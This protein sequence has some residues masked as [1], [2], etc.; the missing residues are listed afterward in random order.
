[1]S[2][3]SFSHPTQPRPQVFRV[4]Q[5]VHQVVAVTLQV[6]RICYGVRSGVSLPRR[7]AGRQPAADEDPVLSAI[8]DMC[9]DM[10]EEVGGCPQARPVPQEELSGPHSSWQLLPSLQQEQ[11]TRSAIPSSSTW[12][13]LQGPP[14]E[15]SLQQIPPPVLQKNYHGG[16]PVADEIARALPL[17]GPSIYWQH[18]SMLPTQ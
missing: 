8:L 9:L 5:P 18:S 7:L 13:S 1:M 15:V 14:G 6:F 3:G 4:L 17:G 2:P 11:P 16:W 12:G 10:E